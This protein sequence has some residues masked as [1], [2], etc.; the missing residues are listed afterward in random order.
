MQKRDVS[1]KEYFLMEER[2]ADLINGG[3]LEG[4]QIVKA[5]DVKDADSS[6]FGKIVWFGRRTVRQ[7]YRD[8]VRKIMFG[9]R[10]V[11]IGIEEQSEIH[12]AMPVRARKKA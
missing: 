1:T 8:I 5:S 3:L 7:R 2:V 12:D 9:T 6:V 4:Q 10:F 11:I